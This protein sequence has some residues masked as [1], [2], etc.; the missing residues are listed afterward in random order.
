MITVPE[1][2]ADALGEFL[3]NYMRRRWTSSIHLERAA[4]D[5]QPL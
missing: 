4:V 3:A 2:A 5:R 1:L